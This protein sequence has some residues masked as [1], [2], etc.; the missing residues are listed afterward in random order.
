MLSYA[1]A[2]AVATISLVLFLT[3]FLMSDIH[4]KD[5]FLWSGVGFI[6]ALVLWFCARNIT[7]A[8]LLGQA[9]ATAVLV[10]STW[11]TLKL[12][13]AIANPDRAAE[14]YNFSV[15]QKIQGLLKRKQPQV[16]STA[17]PVETPVTP[18]VT[19]R[20]IA[21]PDTTSEATESVEQA[22][23][24]TETATK[25]N[26]P[27]AEPEI[28]QRSTTPENQVKTDSQAVVPTDDGALESKENIA[29][30]PTS[31]SKASQPKNNTAQREQTPKIT[32]VE[33][34]VE[35]KDN[36]TEPATSSTAPIEPQVEPEPTTV[37]PASRAIAEEDS[38]PKA[39]TLD[40]KPVSDSAPETK[41]PVSKTSSLDS[42]ET[43]EVAEVLEA[44]S[45]D[46]S[47]IQETDDSSIIEVTTTEINITTEVKKVEQE[48]D[49][50]ESSRES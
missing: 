10:S 5:D 15:W 7:G 2:I 13:R 34:Q 32:S 31:S 33:P 23:Q 19:E 20:E 16:K 11:Q 14:I 25:V 4:R 50:P 43:V 48:P 41:P 38:E 17:T 49:N 30:N 39:Q 24:A 12:R 45:Q 22:A 44:S 6:Y 35:T 36:I 26:A 47:L 3:A 21:I 29:R 37:T 40:I 46:V 9:A 27:K 28:P 42:L 18:K 1:L 8:V